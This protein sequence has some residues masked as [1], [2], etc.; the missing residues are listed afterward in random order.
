MGSST[1]EK[2]KEKSSMKKEKKKEKKSTAQ[3]LVSVATTKKEK[4]RKHESS[5]SSSS[6]DDD[7]DDD[8]KKKDDDDVKKRPLKIQALTMLDGQNSDDQENENGGYNSDDVPNRQLDARTPNPLALEN[9]NLSKEVC[10]A[11]QKKGIDALFEIQAKTFEIGLT[12][13]DI[14]GRARTGCGKTLAFVLPIIEQINKQDPLPKSG[15]RTQG[16]RPVVCV[17]CPTREL[18]KQV[19]ADFEWIGNAFNLKTVCV[20]GG[21]PY[22]DQEQGLRMG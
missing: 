17:L 3:A 4:K 7:E 11:L 21:A 16:R 6:S 12:G 15:K 13:K 14:V 19:G 5:S 8:D 2:K 10:Q 1:K 22:R 9:F 20:Y 18:A